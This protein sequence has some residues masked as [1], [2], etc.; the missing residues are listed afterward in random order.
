MCEFI[1]KVSNKMALNSK[2]NTTSVSV[3]DVVLNGILEVLSKSN[4]KVWSGTM[5]E[6]N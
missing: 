2:T 5:T 6:L 3:D 1:V 4:S